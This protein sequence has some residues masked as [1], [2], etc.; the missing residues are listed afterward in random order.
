VTV[1]LGEAEPARARFLDI[2][3]GGFE[4]REDARTLELAAYTDEAGEARARA[5][6]PAARTSDVVPGW[7]ERWREFHRPVRIGTLWVGPPWEEPP[8]DA[9]PVVIDP[10]RAF[11]TGGHATTR[12]CLGLL[13]D[14]YAEL[15]GS[16]VLDVGCGSG[17]VAIAAARLGYTPVL[18][19]DV[20][21]EAVEAT[22]RSAAANA[23]EVEVSLA[24]ALRVEL[25]TASLAVANISRAAV[26]ELAP[27]LRCRVLVASG[28]LEEDP[29]ALD[30]FE[31]RERRLAEGWAAD[32][33]ERR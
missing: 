5:A 16:S 30:G 33:Y 23:V 32:V 14:L 18:A 1:P 24:D 31:H 25:P 6:F 9:L 7:E 21:P 26:E 13:V 11:G 4:E 27:R 12:L 2:F 15:D 19:V 29:I 22:L 28:Y 10:A 3:P 8:P 17:V 20:E